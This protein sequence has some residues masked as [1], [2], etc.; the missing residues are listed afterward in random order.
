[1]LA[2][3]AEAKQLN[4]TKT[5]VPTEPLAEGL[6][7]TKNGN[8]FPRT[9]QK[10]GDGTFTASKEKQ[11][12]GIVWW[13]SDT[14]WL[15]GIQELSSSALSPQSLGTVMPREWQRRIFVYLQKIRASLW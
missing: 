2:W 13:A 12:A 8:M 4:I 3:E 7:G 6:W 14:K 15:M 5:C 11:P 9:G 10:T 1:M